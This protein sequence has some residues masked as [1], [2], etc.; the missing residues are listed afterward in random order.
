MPVSGEDIQ[1]RFQRLGCCF[2]GLLLAD[3]DVPINKI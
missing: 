1:Y 3:E 2:D